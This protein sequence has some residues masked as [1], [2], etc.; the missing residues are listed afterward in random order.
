MIIT[1]FFFRG[2][3]SQLSITLQLQYKG[4]LKTFQLSVRQFQ[5]LRLEIAKLLSEMQILEK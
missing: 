1:I 3:C 4:S 5:R 2:V